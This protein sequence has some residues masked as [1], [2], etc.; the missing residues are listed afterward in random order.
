[1]VVVCDLVDCAFNDNKFCRQKT[2]VLKG[3]VCGHLIDRHGQNKS[4]WQDKVGEEYMSE[5]VIENADQPLSGD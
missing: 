1:M 4:D 3:G 2:T 5:L